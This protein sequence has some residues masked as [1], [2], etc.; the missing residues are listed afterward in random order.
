M[1]ECVLFP[2]PPVDLYRLHECHY[3]HNKIENQDTAP[4]HR[5]TLGRTISI[6]NERPIIQQ[7]ARHD[8]TTESE[9]RRVP[10]ILVSTY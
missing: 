7:Y 3:D 6:K 1:G 9:E 10:E 8:L 4:S 2:A 5:E